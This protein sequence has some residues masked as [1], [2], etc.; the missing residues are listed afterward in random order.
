MEAFKSIR[1]GHPYRE[2]N[3]VNIEEITAKLMGS[4]TGYPMPYEPR[5]PTEG[6]FPVEPDG[7]IGN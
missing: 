3:P 4:F 1:G 7:G 6:P 2:Y 5:T